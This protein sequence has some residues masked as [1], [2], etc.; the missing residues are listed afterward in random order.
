[1]LENERF[2]AHHMGNK[3]TH[4]LVMGSESPYL[5]HYRTKGSKN[6]VRLYQYLSGALTP[7]GRQHYGIG[8]PRGEKTDKPEKTDIRVGKDV[9]EIGSINKQGVNVTINGKQL[10]GIRENIK[11]KMQEASEARRQRAVEKNLAKEEKRKE[12]EARKES[13]KL[14]KEAIAEAERKKQ[15]E[16]AADKEKAVREALK[17]YYREHPLQIYSARDVLT[18]EEMKEVQGKIVMDRQLKDFRRDE[19]MRYVKT[20]KDVADT[21]D[22]LY[23][24]ADS[25]KKLYNTGAEA[26][27]SL[28]AAKDPNDNKKPLPTIDNKFAVKKAVDKKNGSEGNNNPGNQNDGNADK[29][30]KVEK[31]Q[32]D[33]KGNASSD[34][35]KEMAAVE[36]ASQNDEKAKEAKKNFENIAGNNKPASYKEKPRKD[37]KYVEKIKTSN[38]DTRYFYD[39]ESVKA[40]K[41]NKSF[42]DKSVKAYSKAS[43][44]ERMDFL[45]KLDGIQQERFSDYR[46]RSSSEARK[47]MAVMQAIGAFE[48]SNKSNLSHDDLEENTISLSEFLAELRKNFAN[49]LSSEMQEVIHGDLPT[50]ELTLDEFYDYR[51]AKTAL[52]ETR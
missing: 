16:L 31:P 4:M 19:I 1:M 2:V 52:L 5:A 46:S 41:E 24:G 12:E 38:G 23:K 17:D 18:P 26:Y 49:D 51:E 21:I 29:K 47:L 37:A 40:Y 7:L 45:R 33:K 43:Q 35:K 42:V 34:V 44:A 11:Q 50:A 36:Q 10:G 48:E 20:A 39:K 22:T 9:K 6:G 28:I 13:E 30:Q 3:S 15:E 8:P 32:S 27:N 25:L 14:A